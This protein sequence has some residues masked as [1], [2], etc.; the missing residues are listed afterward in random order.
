MSQS[1]LLIRV[2]QTLTRARIP[3]M[4]TGSVA[5]SLRYYLEEID[6]D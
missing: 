5:S 2:I 3:Y 6:E 1:E 4:I